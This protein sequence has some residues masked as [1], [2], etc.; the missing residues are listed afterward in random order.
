MRRNGSETFSA[1]FWLQTR[2]NAEGVVPAFGGI[3]VKIEDETH[4]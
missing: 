4:K 2:K 3:A 1:T